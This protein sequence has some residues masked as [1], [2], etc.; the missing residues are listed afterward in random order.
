[1]QSASQDTDFAE[2]QYHLNRESGGRVLCV[3]STASSIIRVNRSQE[4]AVPRGAQLLDSFLDSFTQRQDI[5]QQLPAARRVIARDCIAHDEKLTLRTLR[6]SKGLSQK[7]LSTK[8]GTSQAAVSEYESR[9]RKPAEDMIRS[10]SES[11]EV[12][13]NTLMEALA[14]G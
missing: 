14:N 11:L 6:L 9:Q 3:S 12:D 2:Y 10:L 1:M 13:F 4:P 7:E 8:L 5:S